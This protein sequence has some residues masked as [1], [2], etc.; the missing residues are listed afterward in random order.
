MVAQMAPDTLDARIARIAQTIRLSGYEGDLQG[1]PEQPEL[2]DTTLE[3]FAL[4]AMTLQPTV[5][6]DHVSAGIAPLDFAEQ[7]HQMLYATIVQL[8]DAGQAADVVT[9]H[10][11]LRGQPTYETGGGLEYVQALAEGC[12]LI[13]MAHT[14]QWAQIIREMAV[15][16]RLIGVGPEVAAAVAG[17]PDLAAAVQRAQEI[18]ARAV[19]ETGTRV[20]SPHAR[21]ILA[22][23]DEHLDGWPL[24]WDALNFYTQGMATGQ[25]WTIIGASSHGK[26]A[27]VL[28]ILHTALGQERRVAY[29][30]LD[31][32]DRYLLWRLLS[33]ET[34][35]DRYAV[36]APQQPD[37]VTGRAVKAAREKFTS[38]EWKDSIKFYSTYRDLARILSEAR[39]HKMAYGLDI[40]V[41]DYLQNVTMTGASAHSEY[42]RIN[43]VVVAFQQLAQLEDITVVLLSQVSI[44]QQKGQRSADAVNAKGSGSVK[45]TSDITLELFRDRFAQGDEKTYLD[46]KVV[47]V[48]EGPTGKVALRMNLETGQLGQR[49]RRFQDADYVSWLSR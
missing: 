16:R 27:F 10:H 34:G 19:R 1:T 29:F 7:V 43:N 14:T 25:L 20:A 32:H 44:E 28:N 41:V 39:R 40:L 37:T 33:L 21:D 46:V 49:E 6:Q 17:A 42:E 11:M 22:E 30:N 31:S 5:V 3:Q 24:P 48:K 26:T 45:D 8:W 4:V 13:S 15:R 9:L 47:K 23:A 12:F 38:G 36:R 18:L 35:A 2:M